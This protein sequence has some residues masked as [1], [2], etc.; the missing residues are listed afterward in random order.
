MKL[1]KMFFC[2]LLLLILIPSLTGCSPGRK[3]KVDKEGDVVIKDTDDDGNEVVINEKKWEKSEMHGLDAPKATIETSVLS[4]DGNMYG[5]SNMKEKDAK[6][7]IENLK[8]E[9]F[10][11][12]S[13]TM[14]DYLYSGTNKEGLTINFSYDKDSETGSIMSAKGDPPSEEEDQNTAVIGTSDEKWDS[15]IMGG[16]PDPGVKIGAFWTADDAAYYNLE[17]I[18]SYTDY[19]EI[20][21]DHGFTQDIDETEIDSVYIYVATNSAG[22]RITFSVSTD[23]TTIVFEKGN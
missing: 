22:D 1:S 16:L 13:F 7:Y 17:V 14:D 12:N 8:S 11:Y 23:M 2:M 21:K 5:F 15:S 20:I 3:V 6:D 4:T 18:P 19:V 9:G 10:T